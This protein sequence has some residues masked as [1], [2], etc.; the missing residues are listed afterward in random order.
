MIIVET[1]INDIKRKMD[2]RKQQQVNADK[3]DTRNLNNERA[4]YKKKSK[5]VT[6]K[7][8]QDLL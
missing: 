3:I 5:E 6:N 8:L 7:R 4:S 1:N 2:E